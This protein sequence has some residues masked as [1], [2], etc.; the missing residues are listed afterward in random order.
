MTWQ[1]L[2]HRLLLR[3]ASALQRN[4]DAASEKNL[5]R[6]ANE[7]RNLTIKYPYRIAGANR[8]TIGDDVFIGPNSV[9]KASTQ[10]PGPAM[11]NDI[12]SVDP[13]MYDAQ[14][15]I[16]NRV[17]VSGS[18]QLTAFSRIVIEDDVM[19]A[20]N[21]NIT[22][23]LHGYEKTDVPYKY[24]TMTRNKPITIGSGS[25]IGQNVVILPGVTIGRQCIVGANST[26]THS[27]PDCTIAAGSPA[28]V[29][30][31]WDDHEN[32]WKKV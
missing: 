30:S 7:Q 22:D 3:L 10:Y 9:I 27:I 18:L 25:W 29:I 17:S 8:I 23:A 16:G 28:R 20:T 21:I 5:P 19:F 32:H 4:W 15:K 13:V 2:K 11:S 14:V 26:V 31:K 6:F 12:H 24:Q 1:K